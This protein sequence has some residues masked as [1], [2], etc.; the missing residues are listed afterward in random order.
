M[1]DF[2]LIKIVPAEES[3][4]EFS[5]QVKK[6]AYSDYIKQ[7][8]GWDEDKVREFHVQD[9]LNKR[10]EIILYDNEPIGTIYL[11]ENKDYIEIGQFIILSEYQN[12]GIGSYILKGIIEEADH[13]GRVI[14][15]EYLRINP[16][17]TLYQRMGFH[18]VGSNDIFIS[19]E[20]KPGGKREIQSRH[21]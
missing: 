19:V 8:W 21:L 3:H 5:Y 14:K 12:K 2:Y 16:V 4:S 20:R 9:W 6:A 15:L 11:N 17:A 7:I 13:S 1:I 10:P 18:V